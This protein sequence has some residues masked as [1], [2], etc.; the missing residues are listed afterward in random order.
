[1]QGL[2]ARSVRDIT[3]AAFFSSCFGGV[4]FFFVFYR[5]ATISIIMSVQVQ[6]LDQ[7]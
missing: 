4:F 6:R 2:S 7:V 5:A 3:P 1:M